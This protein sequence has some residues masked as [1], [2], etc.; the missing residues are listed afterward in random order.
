VHSKKLSTELRE[1]GG[2][3]GVKGESEENLARYERGREMGHVGGEPLGMDTKVPEEAAVE[4]NI[5]R[6]DAPVEPLEFVG[7]YLICLQILRFRFSFLTGFSLTVLLRMLSRA[8]VMCI[9][10]RACGV[11]N[12]LKVREVQQENRLLI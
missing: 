1:E 11:A 4:L 2:V 7:K 12:S 9:Q 5:M 8:E 3:L 6:A 10:S